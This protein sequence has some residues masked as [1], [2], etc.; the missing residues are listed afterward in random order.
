MRTM[1]WIESDQKLHSAQIQTHTKTH[2]CLFVFDLIF[3]LH[4]DNAASQEPHSSLIFGGRKNTLAEYK[5]KN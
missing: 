5:A 2:R 1:T 4:R 3:H